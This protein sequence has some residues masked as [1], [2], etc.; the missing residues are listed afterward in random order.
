M[1]EMNS[2]TML[3]I[4]TTVAAA[5]GAAV[6]QLLKADPEPVR[7]AVEETQA[8][9][10][11]GKKSK[12]KKKEKKS[13]KKASKAVQ[14]MAAEAPPPV[15]EEPTQPEPEP[16]PEPA[17][18]ESAKAK[19]SKK[20]KKKSKGGKA[21]APAATPAKPKAEP[22]PKEAPKP[23]KAKVAASSRSSDGGWT[24]VK[25]RD[26]PTPVAPA[27]VSSDDGAAAAG[28]SKVQVVI[29]LGSNV[30][31]V[32][33]SKGKT[34]NEIQSTSGAL[35][36]IDKEDSNKPITISGSAE[37]VADAEAQIRAIIQERVDYDASMV[38]EKV[39]LEQAKHKVIIG[40]GGSTIRRI[41]TE[42]GC[43]LI[44]PRDDPEDFI[45][46]RGDADQVKLAKKLI[47]NEI[48][49]ETRFTIP[50]EGHPLGVS[51]VLS[52]FLANKAAKLQEL[53]RD[54]GAKIDINRDEKTIVINGDTKPVLAC[55]MA[56]QTLLASVS[57]SEVIPV[58][59]PKKT[60]RVIGRGGEMVRRLQDE[61]GAR[62]SVDKTTSTVT[63]SGTTQQISLARGKIQALLAA[64]SVAPLLI[65]GEVSH[66]VQV[67]KS[68]VGK[69]IGSKGAQIRT[70]QE[71]SGAKINMGEAAG[72]GPV[73]CVIYGAKAAVA[74]AVAAVN[75]LLEEAK[76]QEEARQQRIATDQAS[77][78]K[79]Q[80]TFGSEAF[81][82][83]VEPE[84]GGAAWGG[85]PAAGW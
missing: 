45:T 65:A 18:D 33:G 67:P 27:K 59:D 81:S 21:E 5:I 38:T 73:P 36:N 54:S 25:G 16:E 41:E 17:K 71:E 56:V 46:L 75:K 53:E 66:T 69:V 20:K 52:L 31:M 26:A 4:G 49:G 12:D 13:K 15:A 79:A 43:R 64:D 61:T 57:N 7:E 3:A 8:K 22:K 40:K 62:I 77:R 47:K 78:E 39:P 85:D 2:L 58:V 84:A 24:T 10:K 29:N 63:V 55:S 51:G 80:E 42:S 35:C 37:E 72:G 74:K 28:P 11:K 1:S 50:Y 60:G 34:I 83:P 82:A 30:S 70:L 32:I 19:K 76:E 23:K 48:E 9:S 14:E 68:A 44:I 6:L